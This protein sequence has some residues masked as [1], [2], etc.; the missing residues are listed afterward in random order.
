MA[1]QPFQKYCMEKLNFKSNEK[2]TTVFTG[3]FYF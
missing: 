1:L 3:R 2:D